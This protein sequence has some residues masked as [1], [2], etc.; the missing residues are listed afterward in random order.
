MLPATTE[1]DVRSGPGNCAKGVPQLLT[2][3]EPDLPVAYHRP[4]RF[5][6]RS[7]LLPP[8]DLAAQSLS[9]V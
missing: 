9:R 6:Y 4:A 5:P 3:P 2:V 7:R 1:Y 8:G